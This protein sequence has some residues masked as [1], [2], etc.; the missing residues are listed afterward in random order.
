VDNEIYRYLPSVIVGTIDKLASIGNQRK[1]SQVFGSIDGRCVK[2]GYYKSK[3]CQKDCTDQTLLQPGIPTGL[4][5]PT[6]FVQDE[7]HLLKEGLGT[8]DGHYETF[9]QQLLREL[10]Q[11]APLKI[12]AS[13]AT[14]EAFQRQINHLYGRD[15]LR[16]RVCVC[17]GL[18]ISE[19]LALRWSDVDWLNGKLRV[20]RAIVRQKV[21]DVKT[22]YS[23]KLMSVDADMLA[24]LKPCRQSTQFSG[25][26]IGFS[27]VPRS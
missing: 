22:V 17:F 3:C 2:H 7:L 1:L 14:I 24:V 8:F 25:L 15:P 4:S 27:P 26:R 12:I 6:L 9:T 18:R 11:T 23:G 16:A 20:E 5:G 19:C 10:G 21:D 13:S